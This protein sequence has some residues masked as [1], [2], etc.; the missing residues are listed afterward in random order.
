LSKS[1]ERKESGSIMRRTPR[2]LGWALVT[3][4]LLTVGSRPAAAYIK[5]PPRTLGGVCL[6]PDNIGV[7]KVDK[8]SAEN[9]VIVFKHVQQLKGKHDD[10]VLKH[11]IRPEV[12]GAKIILDWAAEGK[13]AVMFSFSEGPN[14]GNAHVYIDG[15]W[16]WSMA[17]SKSGK[18]AR[19]EG[20]WSAYQGEPA[21]LALFC[22]PADKL[23]D[24]VAK[25][26]RGEEVEVPCL[27]SDDKQALEQRRGKIQQV[28]AS[29]KLVGADS[30]TRLASRPAFVG[31]VQ[32][33]SDDGKS[34]T[35]LP[36]PTE[37]DKEPAAVEIQISENA[38]ITVEGSKEPV[39]LAVGRT[40]SVW[41]QMK[42]GGSASLAVMIQISKPSENPEKKPEDV[43]KK[44]SPD[45]PEKKPDGKKPVSLPNTASGQH[46]ADIVTRK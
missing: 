44:P 40:V 41:L 34:F 43:G 3:A 9:G 35:I 22:G 7:L 17:S 25:I 1:H 39:K 19:P 12:K 29:L 18:E 13:T 2:Y 23:G 32:A 28:R 24:A 36:R 37:K 38:T 26:L 33:L 27:A 16:F 8:V 15:Y 20:W 10:T 4:S 6:E 5:V 31:T 46:F 21:L 42:K 30:L 45:A 14:R 11:V